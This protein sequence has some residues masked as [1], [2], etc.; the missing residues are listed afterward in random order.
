MG[1]MSVAITE[2]GSRL[3]S[4]RVCCGFLDWSGAKNFAILGMIKLGLCALFD[5]I[6]AA[7]QDGL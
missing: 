5:V 6:P 1:E 7:S 4:L 3:A 2:N